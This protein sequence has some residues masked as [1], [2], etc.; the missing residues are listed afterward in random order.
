[1]SCPMSLGTLLEGW[2]DQPPVVVV[3]GL[4]LDSRHVQPGEAFVAVAGGRQ[5]GLDFALQAEERGAAVVIHDGLAP[6]PQLGIPAVAVDGLGARLSALAARFFHAPSERLTVAGVTGTNG[7]TSTA[8]FIAQAWHRADGSA[9]LIGTLG[10]GALDRLRPA[11]LTTPDPISVQRALSECIDAGV[12]RVAMEVSSH[13]LEQGRCADVAFEAAVLTNLSRDHLDYHGSMD[14]YAAA[15]RRLFTDCRPR[16]A[17]INADDEFGR[18]LADELEGGCQ[19]LSYGMRQRAELRAEVVGMDASGLNLELAGPWGGGRIHTGLMGRFNVSNLLAAAGTLALLGMPWSQVL[20]QLEL[21]H[22]VPGR[23]QCL[24]GEGGQPVVVVDFAHTPDALREALTALGAHLHGRLTCVFGCG[25][26]RDRGKRP[27]MAAIAEKLA[28]R[29]V[30]T[31]DNPR[32]ESLTEIF[33]DMQT[34]LASPDRALVIA[35]R[36][37]A[38]RRAIQ[39]SRPGDIVLIAGKGHETWQETNGQRLPFSDEAAVR[40][41]LEEAA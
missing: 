28:D 34:G 26:D 33:A 15:K 37:A 31:A 24:G 41:V 3:T 23:M 16:F 29:V 10:Y 20:H 5:H 9:G 4:N 21:M 17:V 30:L 27:L 2:C 40:A 13:A 8:H 18:S 35:D 19:V 7:K 14:N 25:G 1:M 11:R 36:S 32:G 12:E 38:I 39:D 6:V 22:P